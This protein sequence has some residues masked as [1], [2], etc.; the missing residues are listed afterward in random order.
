MKLVVKVTPITNIVKP[1]KLHAHEEIG[2]IHGSSPIE[3]FTSL[4]SWELARRD[5]QRNV[6]II[7]NIYIG[8]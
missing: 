1:H 2:V 6:D 4:L 7:Y 5:R 8:I 3:L